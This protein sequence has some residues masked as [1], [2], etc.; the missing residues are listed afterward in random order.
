M[1][2]LVGQQLGQYHLIDILGEGGIA[3]VYRARR[4]TDR[5][6]VAIKVIK[7]GIVDLADFV[8]CIDRETLVGKSLFHPH[9]LNV[10]SYGKHDK[11][12]Y[13]VMPLLSGGNLGD[14]IQKQELS[15]R[16]I[17]RIT[18]QIASALDYIHAQGFVHRDVKPENI[19]I[20][21][22]GKAC[23]S[24]F[25]LVK[26]LDEATRKMPSSDNKAWLSTKKGT[27]IGTP[28]YMS[29]EQ[30]KS[31]PV[32][33]RSDVYS[34][35]VVLFELLTGELPFTCDSSIEAMYLHIK[36]TPPLISNVRPDL[37]SELDDIIQQ[38]LAKKPEDRFATAGA[39]AT[40][41]GDAIDESTA[42]IPKRPRPVR[43]P[44]LPKATPPEPP[45]QPSQKRRV[46]INRPMSTPMWLT[47][48]AGF[49]AVVVITA[50][51]VDILVSV[52][53]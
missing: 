30:C 41:L 23:L 20:D 11:T 17:S 21:E 15:L 46:S 14:L 22:F 44:A 1:T 50:V 33:G 26:A 48:I 5:F 2:T 49:V 8:K 7:P 4:S 6:D 52:T 34:L 32:D 31:E 27:V 3:H 47:L 39:L 43:S 12:V 51:I 53:A 19:L 45:R 29:P 10:H 25:G 40:A 16:A 37:P 28:G 42:T 9:V 38:A 13:M 24:D 36:K 18:S 35:G